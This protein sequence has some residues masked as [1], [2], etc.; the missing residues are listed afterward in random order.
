VSETAHQAGSGEPLAAVSILFFQPESLELLATV[1]LNGPR[2]PFLL[3]PTPQDPFELFL[4]MPSPPSVAVA[5]VAADGTSAVH[6]WSMAAIGGDA[7]VTSA[8]LLTQPAFLL[9]LGLADGGV[10]VLRRFGE[11]NCL[12]VCGIHRV[13]VG[14]ASV[15]VASG[16]LTWPPALLPPARPRL[17]EETVGHGCRMA[18]FTVARSG[19]R[20]FWIMQN[21]DDGL[22]SSLDAKDLG[23]KQPAHAL[24]AT[25]KGSVTASHLPSPSLKVERQWQRTPPASPLADH[26]IEEQHSSPRVPVEMPKAELPRSPLPRSLPPEPSVEPKTHQQR[27]SRSELEEPITFWKAA[28]AAAASPSKLDDLDDF[29][30]LNDLDAQVQRGA[31]QQIPFEAPRD[32]LDVLIQRTARE[33]AELE[34]KEEMLRQRAYQEDEPA[35]RPVTNPEPLVALDV[36]VPPGIARL[37][38]ESRV[39]RRWARTR[40]RLVDPLEASRAYLERTCRPQPR[41]PRFYKAPENALACLAKVSEDPLQNALRSL[42][43]DPLEAHMRSLC[44]PW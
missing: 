17:P 10:A 40:E 3:S 25:R 19:A 31:L 12:E 7:S 23:H 39:E 33:I 32:E 43:V 30:D 9:C 27:S 20:R 4:V 18:L 14:R 15:V 38:R 21:R 11:D 5:Q 2:L 26:P 13:A 16:F 36:P 28:A 8:A 1:E 29:D 44:Q 22:P 34:A 37:A 42:S 35:L 24:G 41:G 6:Q